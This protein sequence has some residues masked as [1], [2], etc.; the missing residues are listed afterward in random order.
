MDLATL[1]H[2]INPDPRTIAVFWQLADFQALQT[3]DADMHSA[4]CKNTAGIDSVTS[5]IAI[6]HRIDSL[7]GG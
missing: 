1:W 3:L 4:V 2:F 7:F 6:V 5:T